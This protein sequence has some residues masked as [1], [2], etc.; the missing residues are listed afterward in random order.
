MSLSMFH[1]RPSFQR[2]EKDDGVGPVSSCRS[3]VFR[4]YMCLS[5]WLA[6][7]THAFVCLLGVHTQP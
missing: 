6:M 4:F 3:A 1:Y 5:V 2:G 7:H